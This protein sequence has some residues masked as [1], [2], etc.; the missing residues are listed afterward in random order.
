MDKIG[1]INIIG[2]LTVFVISILVAFLLTVKTDR[3]ISNRLFALFL[4]LMALDIGN[5]VLSVFINTPSNFT[6]FRPNLIFLQLPVFYLYILSVCYSDFKLKSKH[7]LHSILFIASNILLIPRF[8]NVDSASKSFFLENIKEMIEIKIIHIS[9]HVQV[10][11]YFIL[12]F[13]VL[14]RYR[15]LYLENY[16]NSG[17]VLYK[18]LFQI[19]SIYAS[20]HLIALLKN[21]FKYNA[22]ET[23]FSGVQIIIG[24][25]ALF[26]IC[27]HLLKALKHP[28]LFRGVH[29]KLQLVN[30]LVAN[31]KNISLSNDKDIDKLKTYMDKE[32]PFLDPSLTIQHLS[33]KINIPVRDLSILINHKLGQ[34][35]FDFVNE[36][37]IKKAMSIL[38]DPSK[39]KLTV[40]EILYEVG[41][42][43]KSSFNTA[44]KKH[45]GVTPTVY[46]KK[47]LNQL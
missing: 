44:F 28:D 35:F 22:S 19:T 37:R 3:K 16:T 25:L 30:D 33:D 41:F 7:V 40:L 27:W 9:I 2:I 13:S 23:F 5:W 24:L 12:I 32:E 46:R 8:Y 43:S 4:I 39:N 21:I 29:S 42:N 36:Y 31:D 17:D 38:K 10:F 47:S 45:T 26:I 11:F 15:K 34:H 14:K 20:I 6:L 18:W 1:L